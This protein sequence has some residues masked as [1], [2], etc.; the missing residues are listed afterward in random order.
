MNGLEELLELILEKSNIYA[1]Q[2]GRN[3]TVTK[4]ELKAFLGKSFLMTINKL[5]RIVE[6]WRVD[7]LVHNDGIHNTVFRR[8]C[9]IFQNLHF[10][11]NGKDDKKG[12]VLKMRPVIQHLNSKFSE[13]ISSDSEQSIDENMV[14]FKKRSGMKQHIKSKPKKWSFKFLIH[15]SS[16]SSYLYQV[17]IYLGRKQTPAFNLGLGEEVV[18]QLTKDLEE[19]LKTVYLTTFLIVQS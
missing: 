13:V 11:D 1:H 2:N 3:I 12:K 18:L 4:E 7:N 17:D 14:K 10:T 5:P 16:K 9:E 6:Y 15:C 8:F 19:S